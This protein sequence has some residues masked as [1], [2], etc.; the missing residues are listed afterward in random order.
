MKKKLIFSTFAFVLLTILCAMPVFAAS[1]TA[2]VGSAS[3]NRG[4]TVKVSVSL[5]SAT[6]VGSGGIE[7][8]YDTAVLELV[9][10]EWNVSGTSLATF[11]ASNNKGAFAYASG[12]S[13]SGKVFTATFKIKSNA[14][15]GASTVKMI[16]QLK[17]GSN[18]D[19]SVTNNSSKV[20]VTCKHNYS[21]WSSVNGTS[22]IRTCS[23]CNQPETKN[24]AFSNACDT[25]C[26]DCGYTRTTT[27]NYKTTWSYDGSKHWHECSVCKDKK[28][29]AD[30]TPGAPATETTPQK[31]T[32]CDRVLVEVAGHTHTYGDSWSS[33]TNGHW[34]ICSSCNE[35]S[36]TEAHAYDNDCDTSCNT[37]GHVRTVTHTY[38]EEFESDNDKHW[39]VCEI[40]GGSSEKIAHKYDNGCDT[41]CNDCGH[42]REAN[43][44]FDK[45]TVTK[46]ATKNSAGEKTYTCSE[47]GA[48]KVVELELAD[49][50][51]SEG[52]F[53]IVSMLIGIVIGA[54]IGFF[55]SMFIFKKKK[56]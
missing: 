20:T 28:D 42:T 24:H 2:N 16:L 11:N 39:Q 1:A 4:A 6:T 48:T 35:K 19:I 25:T 53:S 14:A 13:V 45:G 3:G 17:D 23:I 8:V 44:V 52:G 15:F 43:H 40:C 32:V 27:H 26:N 56:V 9:K 10:G 30:H 36:A 12:T 21:K 33:D 5:S 7:L 38:E 55:V 51:A 18:A 50:G 54:A 22:H 29:V 49:G 34:K 41:E 31:C 37:C 47:C 46:K